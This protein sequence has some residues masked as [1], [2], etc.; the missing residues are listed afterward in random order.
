MGCLTAYSKRGRYDKVD[1]DASKQ[2]LIYRVFRGSW[3]LTELG[4]KKMS[5]IALILETIRWA[6]Q[7]RFPDLL[8]PTSPDAGEWIRVFAVVQM[9]FFVAA[10]IAAGGHIVEAIRTRNVKNLNTIGLVLYLAWWV[11]IGL[12]GGY[13][14]HLAS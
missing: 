6:L 13:V 8:H 4:L 2:P 5:V 3:S 11:E 9:I 1:T 12:A 10:T 7:G 14:G